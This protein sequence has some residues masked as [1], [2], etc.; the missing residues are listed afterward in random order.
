MRSQ[1]IITDTPDTAS[2][3]FEAQLQPG[4]V[5]LLYVYLLANTT[6]YRPM[7]YR[8]TF[9][10]PTFHSSSLISTIFSPTLQT[11]IST[12]STELRN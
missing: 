10:Y 4:D 3:L 8:I 5:I 11:P 7:D 6:D 2:D 9:H 12:H 1:G